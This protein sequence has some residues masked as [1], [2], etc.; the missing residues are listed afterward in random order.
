MNFK[1]C[2]LWAL[3][4]YFLIIYKELISPCKFW[5]ILIHFFSVSGSTF[6][7]SFGVY[8]HKK[9]ILH[10]HAINFNCYIL[11]ILDEKKETSD[12]SID[13]PASEILESE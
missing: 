11:P 6:P 7:Y 8:K 12:R 13:A 10:V 5:N 1:G 2:R 9:Y 3:N 4:I